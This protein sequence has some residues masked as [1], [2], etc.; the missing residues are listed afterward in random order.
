MT[1]EAVPAENGPHISREVRA[2]KI[3]AAGDHN[4]AGYAPRHKESAKSKTQQAA[5][6]KSRPEIAS[7]SFYS[8]LFADRRER[9]D[10]LWRDGARKEGRPR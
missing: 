4:V 7:T 3:G 5:P 6:V 9:P 10:G 1:L 2:R 8:T